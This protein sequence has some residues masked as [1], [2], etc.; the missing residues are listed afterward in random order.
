MILNIMPQFAENFKQIRYTLPV[1][2]RAL[3]FNDCFEDLVV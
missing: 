1:D 3:I 2:T